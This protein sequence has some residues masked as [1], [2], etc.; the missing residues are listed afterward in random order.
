MRHAETRRGFRSYTPSPNYRP[1][2]LAAK[3][4]GLKSE[5]I[6]RLARNAVEHDETLTRLVRAGRAGEGVLR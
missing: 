5:T 1:N 4:G 6:D 3:A 2:P